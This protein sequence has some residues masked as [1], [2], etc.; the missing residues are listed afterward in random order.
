MFPCCCRWLL[1]L[2]LVFLL[3]PLPL[4]SL[5]PVPPLLLLPLCSQVERHHAQL[6]VQAAE[7]RAGQDDD[8]L[9]Q[10]RSEWQKG[11]R[12]AVWLAFSGSCLAGLYRQLCL[13]RRV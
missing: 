8:S 11:R 1:L 3:L 13:P 4:L 9:A 12:D 10:V 6:V 5:L 7:A 2:P